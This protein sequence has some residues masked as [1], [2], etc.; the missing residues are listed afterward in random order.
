MSIALLFFLF[1]PPFFKIFTA[2]LF[3]WWSIT[4]T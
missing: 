4:R 1:L 2:G 3:P